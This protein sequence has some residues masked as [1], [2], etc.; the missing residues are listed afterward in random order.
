[1]SKNW[2]PVQNSD[3]IDA[4]CERLD[5]TNPFSLRALSA[6]P[7]PG[8]AIAFSE[9]AVALR[10]EMTALFHFRKLSG[11][12]EL[13]LVQ[14]IAYAAFAVCVGAEAASVQATP[15]SSASPRLHIRVA[16]V[17]VVQTPF[18]VASVPSTDS[19]SYRLEAPAL[20]QTY[21]F[22]NLPPEQQNP[23]TKRAAVLKTLVIVPR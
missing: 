8:P 6:A 11:N 7:V 18:P 1:M 12:K 9:R 20:A 4:G 5:S 10:S 17:P 2:T 13:R 16:V 21:E 19:I 15:R 14:T 22:R 23:R 3:T